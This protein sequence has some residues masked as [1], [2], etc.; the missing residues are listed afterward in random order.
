LYAIIPLKIAKVGAKYNRKKTL[1]FYVFCVFVHSV[2][3]SLIE[4][5]QKKRFK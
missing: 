1:I 2:G 3:Y 4:I 5:E